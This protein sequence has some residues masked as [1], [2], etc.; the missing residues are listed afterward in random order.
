MRWYH[1]ML[2][3][4]LVRAVSSRRLP[5]HTLA[6]PHADAR[7]LGAGAVLVSPAGAASLQACGGVPAA[8]KGRPPPGQE[9]CC[10]QTPVCRAGLA[11]LSGGGLA[12]GSHFRAAA[13]P[14]TP[15]SSQSALRTSVHSF[16]T[17][18]ASASVARRTCMVSSPAFAQET[19]VPSPRAT[20][21][22]Q[23]VRPGCLWRA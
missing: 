19:R 23:G 18:G 16:A 7:G 12:A 2:N 1:S 8:R 14:T 11:T 20:G 21:I 9:G 13:A 10:R 15:A 4:R 5:P 22:V 17:L 3:S 6:P